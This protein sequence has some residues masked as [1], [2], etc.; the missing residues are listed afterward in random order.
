L[1]RYY[2][3]NNKRYILNTDIL[4]T[5]TLHSHAI[6][7]GGISATLLQAAATHDVL[8]K[9]ISNALD[10]MYQAELPEHIHANDIVMK[11]Q[12]TH[13]NSPADDTV[14]VPSRPA[15][16]MCIPPNVHEV[17][18]FNT[19]VGGCVI[20]YRNLHIPHSFT[21]HH[22]KEGKKGCRS[23]YPAGPCDCTKPVQLKP[24]D[25]A[26][27][28]EVAK[29]YK[30]LDFIE[31]MNINDNDDDDDDD[32]DDNDDEDEDDDK[33]DDKD[34]DEHKDDLNSI[35]PPMDKRII[36]WE[37]KRTLFN[38]LPPVP[39]DMA[40]DDLCIW[41]R[42]QFECILI[43][44]KYPEPFRYLDN[45]SE[46]QAKALYVHMRKELPNRNLSVV[47]FNPLL[48][49]LTGS[50]T[51][52][53]HLGNETQSTNTL[54][55]VA[56]Y[57]TKNK[58]EL[59]DC[60]CTVAR[61]KRDINERPSKA[62]NTGT[63]K[64]T[65]AHL[66]QRS[67]NRMDLKIE[68]S[69][70]QACAALLGME[71]MP[72][73]D[74]YQWYGGNQNVQFIK[75]EKAAKMNA[76]NEMKEEVKFENTTIDQSTRIDD[77][78]ILIDFLTSANEEDRQDKTSTVQNDTS[79]TFDHTIVSDEVK[80]TLVDQTSDEI[81]PTLL[82]QME[83]VHNP[84]ASFDCIPL[85][86]VHSTDDK[87]VKTIPIPYPVLYRNRGK[88]LQ[89]MN[90]IEYYTL[91]KVVRDQ[92]DGS[93]S[94]MHAGRPKSHRF[95][96]GDGFPLQGSYK[97]ILRSKQPVVQFLGPGQMPKKP[98]RKPSQ[99]DQ[100]LYKA[101]NQ[102][103]NAFAE[104]WLVALRAE[105][106][107]YDNS[108]SNDL[109]YDWNTFIKWIHDMREKKELIGHF[110]ITFIRNA[111]KAFQFDK[112]ASI[113]QSKYRGRNHT[114]WSEDE[115]SDAAAAQRLET[116]C[117]TKNEMDDDNQQQSA[118]L[119]PANLSNMM[120][121]VNASKQYTSSMDNILIEHANSGID[122]L[123]L[124]P[125]ENIIQESA[126]PLFN[127][128]SRERIEAIYNRIIDKTCTDEDHDI[129]NNP[130]DMAPFPTIDSY[131]R[132]TAEEYLHHLLQLADAHIVSCNLSDDKLQ[133]ME[134]IKMYLCKLKQSKVFQGI[135]TP[136]PIKL[137]LSGP[138]GSGKS[139]AIFAVQSLVYRLKV[140]HVLSTAFMGL[141][142]AHIDGSTYHSAF[143]IPFHDKEN[144]S[145]L[146]LSLLSLTN[147]GADING[148]DLVL[149]I[150]D[151]I[152]QVAAKHTAYMEAR[153]RQYFGERIYRTIS[154]MFA[155][156][157]NQIPPV[158]GTSIATGAVQMYCSDNHCM[159]Q[160]IRRDVYPQD[161]VIRSGIEFFIDAQ[162]FELTQE[163]RA[164]DDKEHSAAVLNMYTTGKMS[165]EMLRNLRPLTSSTYD[166]DPNWLKATTIVRTN[167]EVKLFEHTQAI[168][169]A[170]AA[171]QHVIRWKMKEIKFETSDS[172]M[173]QQY[174][175]KSPFLWQYFVANSDA[176][177]TD[178]IS[179][180]LKLTN[181]TRVQLHSLSFQ[182]KEDEK[183]FEL[184]CNTA[185]SGSIIDLP[186]IPFSI[187]V[188]LFLKDSHETPNQRKQLPWS[189]NNTL[190]PNK[191]IIPILSTQNRTS[192]TKY[193]MSYSSSAVYV[194]CRPYFPVDPAF[195][196]TSNKCQSRTMGKVI[197]AICKDNLQSPNQQM[198]GFR[199]QALF[200]AISRV[201]R[202]SNIRILF[203]GKPNYQQ[204]Q[205]A[206]LLERPAALSNFLNSYVPRTENDGT[207]TF[208]E[209]KLLSYYQH[210]QYSKPVR[211]LPQH[212]KSD[213]TS[214]SIALTL[215]SQIPETTLPP[216][217]KKKKLNSLYPTTE[218]NNKKASTFTHSV[219]LPNHNSKPSTRLQSAKRNMPTR[220]HTALTASQAL[221]CKGNT[222]QLEYDGNSL[223]CYTFVNLQLT[224]NDC[225]SIQT[226][227]FTHLIV[228]DTAYYDYCK[229]N[230]T[231]WW[232][233]S[234]LITFGILQ[235]HK[236]H[237]NDIFLLACMYPRDTG[238]LLP[239]HLKRSVRT[240]VSIAFQ[241]NHYC[242]LEFILK[243]KTVRVY[244]GLN[245]PID[246]WKDHINQ[247]CRRI[248]MSTTISTWPVLPIYS[249]GGQQMTQS[250]NYNCGPIACMV[251][252][253]LFN[254]PLNISYFWQLDVTNYRSTVIDK[255]KQLL[256][257]N[258]TILQM[259]PSSTNSTRQR[260]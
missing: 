113:I 17:D 161:S 232:E 111:Y 228:G 75:Q 213:S 119:S 255:M 240:V 79:I 217:A 69:D 208:S 30:L 218:Y 18:E 224:C 202:N 129:S 191:A 178:K 39:P 71:S 21:C 33:D 168:H 200:V 38:Q 248:E 254:P 72:S 138:P 186:F 211:V 106:E 74:I 216:P 82:E 130:F 53:Y 62:E 92:S 151:E 155:G 197:L 133:F 102:R 88:G 12:K 34:E 220:S 116:D 68:L 194:K 70:N 149:I 256:T 172:K 237:R 84:S 179:K 250:D 139:W 110:Y 48:S 85:Y 63:A 257:Q 51:A 123:T 234:L 41:I 28:S 210:R 89:V 239:L 10:T 193:T 141:A 159:Q 209:Q 61:A 86:K 244:D 171:H 158:G 206:S 163:N 229:T 203:Y 54:C 76:T 107:L 150:V 225:N 126:V 120:K 73:S 45:L 243:D 108:K 174:D 185:A 231:R 52:A 241:M 100:T 183:E 11:W 165:M 173:D 259:K 189:S 142:A 137:Y 188:Q 24:P 136:A 134:I 196:T 175:E 131:E 19:F 36:V 7:F 105:T 164:S 205:Y 144:N 3:S 64:R 50:N 252:W 207:T 83:N 40:N 23:K 47:A 9:V 125:L 1:L 140:G 42:H 109:Q 15:P 156:D 35:I 236:A 5:G 215:K 170:K 60:L 81:R 13:S 247:I 182:T 80:C 32:N 143:H 49:S 184:L 204:V 260:R 153:L 167:T 199:F 124:H 157:Y 152:S 246:T 162:R 65:V 121:A 226:T 37:M 87:E 56:P 145:I 251:L 16:I 43:R 93:K 98:G 198:Q 227:N 77:D 115:R 2:K 104:F 78:D 22:G 258:D 66:L 20:C 8:S 95:E 118:N 46:P 135:I 160:G 181:G 91:I 245:Y 14:K 219:H 222:Y 230:Q 147:F 29:G 169:F 128:Y 177:L 233:N 90:R 26:D 114:I 25:P 99:E 166:E 4:F 132:M 201:T 253:T 112:Q 238:T 180:R 146:P 59:S 187:N 190:I 55:Y 57:I 127:D 192:E 96:F 103:A 117:Q 214:N 6:V 67:L 58:V 176:F 101:W 242:I 223:T 148:E 154:I 212:V 195:A 44:E 122:A 221:K 27:A 249:I 97:Q 235:A 94:E 31:P